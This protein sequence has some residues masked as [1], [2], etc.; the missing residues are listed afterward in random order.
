MRKLRFIL[1]FLLVIAL[2]AGTIPLLALLSGESYTPFNPELEGARILAHRARLQQG[3][4][5]PGYDFYFAGTSRTMAD[6]APGPVAAILNERCRP[7]PGVTGYN[8]GNVADD[9]GQF[10]VQLHR[11]GAPRLLILELMPSALLAS[12]DAATDA[13]PQDTGRLNQAYRA[14]KN[15]TSIFE[16]YVTGDAR[17]LLGLGDLVTIRPGQVVLLAQALRQSD[18]RLA[19]LYYMLRNFQGDGSRLA[20]LG[21]VYYRSYLPD[22]RAAALSGEAASQYAT[23]VALLKAAPSAAAWDNFVRILDLF[24]ADRQV[25]IVRPP[26]D[27]TLYDLEQR[28]QGELMTRAARYLEERGIAYIDLNPGDYRSTDLSHVDWYDTGALSRDFAAR[29]AA[30]IRPGLLG[31]GRCRM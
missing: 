3:L 2:L 6:F 23:Y 12:A 19:R 27:P 13:A 21:Q 22:R 5:P 26:V 29:L 30:I 8:L 24:G 15:M 20:E 1:P 4:Y 11:V 31:P 7:E 14:Y 9:Y 16:A 18:Q 10:Y 25:V 17:K 28:T